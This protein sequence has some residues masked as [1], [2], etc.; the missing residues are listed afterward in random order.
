MSAYGTINRPV[1]GK[2][3]P[4]KLWTIDSTLAYLTTHHITLSSASRLEGLLDYLCSVFAQEVDDGFTYPQ[5]GPID[6]L[7]F[8][9][10]FF[11]ADV[12]VAIVGITGQLEGGEGDINVDIATARGPRSWSQCIAGFYYV[13]D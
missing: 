2:L 6:R 9:N 5:E 1:S 10:Y 4:T 8:D 12:I 3:L 7:A 11:A 13:S